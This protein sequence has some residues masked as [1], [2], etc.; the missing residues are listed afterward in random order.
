MFLSL[1]TVSWT[2]FDDK[3]NVL[4]IYQLVDI[5]LRQIMS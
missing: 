3:Y 1:I 4:I 5:N 2:Q